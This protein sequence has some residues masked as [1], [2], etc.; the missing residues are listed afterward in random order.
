MVEPMGKTALTVDDALFMRMMLRKILEGAGYEVLEAENGAAG[1][2]KYQ[3]ASPDVVFM[4]ITMPQMDGIAATKGI[5]AINP[6]A[7]V[8]MCTA[9]GQQQQVME[10]IQAGAKDY[11][12]KPFE[13]EKVLQAAAK[14]TGG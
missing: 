9:V 10:A 13:P 3:E 11:I 14:A 5:I 7:Y 8:V 4:D 1:V 2:A 12:M 6:N